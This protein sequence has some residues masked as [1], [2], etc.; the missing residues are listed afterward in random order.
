M[1]GVRDKVAKM[2]REC[3][4]NVTVPRRKRA[5]GSMGAEWRQEQKKQM[6]M[7]FPG[8][9]DMFLSFLSPF[10]TP[11]SFVCLFLMNIKKF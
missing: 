7:L 10:R 5:A 6:S 8:R 11:R 2:I 4:G 1:F 3:S 9:P